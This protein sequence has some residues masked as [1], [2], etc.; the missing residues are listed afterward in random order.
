MVVTYCIQCSHP[1]STILKFLYKKKEGENTSKQANT[2]TQVMAWA[3]TKHD[4]WWAGKGCGIGRSQW[5]RHDTGWADISQVSRRGR[6]HGVT[7]WHICFSIP[8]YGTD[9][10][11]V[12]LNLHS[13][14]TF[15]S[16]SKDSK[17]CKFASITINQYHIF[18][19]MP[20]YHVDYT[21]H[22]THK[23]MLRDT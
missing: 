19:P 22:K 5:Q 10:T 11:L 12:P 21:Y 17:S 20:H 4:H 23:N 1:P 3:R 18:F 9:I 15:N 8:K 13:Y 6:G 2:S 7:S 16:F 14:I